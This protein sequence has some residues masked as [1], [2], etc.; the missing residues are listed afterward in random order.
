M[1]AHDPQPSSVQAPANTSDRRIRPAAAKVAS[2]V[3][4][5]S[6]VAPV[7]RATSAVDPAPVA[8]A[9]R[10]ADLAVLFGDGLLP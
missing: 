8:T 3:S 1:A 9:Y 4:A 5:T 6:A 2:A 7:R 10:S